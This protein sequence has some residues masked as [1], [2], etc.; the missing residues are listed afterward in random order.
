MALFHSVLWLNQY[1]IVY[2]HHSFFIRSSFDGHIGCFHVLVIVNSAA[3]TMGLHVSFWIVVLSRYMPRSGLLN[4]MATLFFL[5]NLRTVCN[6]GCTNLHPTSNAGGFPFLC[7]LS[8][9]HYLR[10]LF[11][12][13]GPFWPVWGGTYLFV[14]L[15]CI[16]LLVSDIERLF[17]SL[18]ATCMSYL[19]RC[20]F[21]SSAHL[22]SM[23]CLYVLEINAMLVAS[24]ANISSHSESCLF[25]LFMVSFA[26][27][28]LL[29]VSHKFIFVFISLL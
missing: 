27:Q 8:S 2:T 10:I 7:S 12:N 22:S 19:E 20:S 14:V 13:W 21:R 18:S 11:F 5:R 24:F 3:L 16:S 6:S 25:I 23:S 9:I 17:M 26:E 4:H 29:S 1:S 15:I 28:R